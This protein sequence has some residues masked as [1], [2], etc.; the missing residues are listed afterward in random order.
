ME[1]RERFRTKESPL[2]TKSFAFALRCIQ[3][4]KKLANGQR[5]F[6]LSKQLLR[7]GTSIGSNVEEANQAESRAD[8]IH[9][10]SIA[11]KEA[12]ETRY[13]L[14]L[15][16]DSSTLTSADADQLLSDCEELIRL[17]ISSLKTAKENLNRNRTKSKSL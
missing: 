6:V 4:Y 14:R 2:R 1:N 12:N 9:K 13:W 5:E 3:T 10:L 8:F 17:L 16:R 7:S 15:L 11:N